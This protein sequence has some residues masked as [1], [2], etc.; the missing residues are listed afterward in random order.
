[1][2]SSTGLGKEFWGCLGAVLAALITGFFSL[3]IAGKLPG[4][5]PILPTITITPAPTVIVIQQPASY[6]MIENTLRRPAKIWIDGV[7][8]GEVDSSDTVEFSINTYPAKVDFE[9]LKQIRDDGV[10]LGNDFSGVWNNIGKEERLTIR[11][12]VGEQ[13]YFA[14]SI[15]N[16]LSVDCDIYVNAGYSTELFVGMVRAGNDAFAGYYYWYPDSTPP[17]RSRRDL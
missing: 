5:P 3:M 8:R 16:K 10:S 14:P 17:N 6:I 2:D 9:V 1:M 12:I 7:Y 11:N 15:H 13:F 4:N